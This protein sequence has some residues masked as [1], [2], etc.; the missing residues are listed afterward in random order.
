MG[1]AGKDASFIWR[2]PKPD[3]QTRRVSIERPK[4][5]N[6]VFGEALAW[7]HRHNRVVLAGTM[8]VIVIAIVQLLR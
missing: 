2:M 7:L 4:R 6:L 5:R 8:L 1:G 3:L